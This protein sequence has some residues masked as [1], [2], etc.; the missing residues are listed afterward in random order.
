MA[1]RDV[2]I[3]PT[4]SSHFECASGQNAVAMEY[5]ILYAQS[6]KGEPMSRLIDL[7]DRLECAIRHINTAL[8]IDTWA[9]NLAV[10]SMRMRI[11]LMKGKQPDI[12]RC[13]DCKH[14]G[15]KPIDDGRYWCELHDTFMYYCS[16]A[17]RRT[18]E[19]D[20]QTD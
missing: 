18:D 6:G 16:D 9:Q 4:K 5:C 10:E 11:A 3:V 2:G 15:E 17:E 13:E 20:K 8:D 19:P 14:R 7:E 12:I 1:T